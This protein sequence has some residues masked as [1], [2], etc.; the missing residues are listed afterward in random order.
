MTQEQA[1]ESFL[2]MMPGSKISVEYNRTISTGEKASHKFYLWEFSEGS[3]RIV[4]SS[5]RCWEHALA[6]AKIETDFPSTT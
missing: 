3:S 5:D 2:M 6:L 4:A 1:L